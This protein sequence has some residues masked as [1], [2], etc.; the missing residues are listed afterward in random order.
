M[1]TFKGFPNSDFL[2]PNTIAKRTTQFIDKN[3]GTVS[4]GSS[5]GT[6]FPGEPISKN[7]NA[8]TVLG[9]TNNGIDN[10]LS[11]GFGLD[12]FP[13]GTLPTDPPFEANNNPLTWKN[14]NALNVLLGITQAQGNI[15]NGTGLPFPPFN[16]F[17]SQ[18]AVQFPFNPFPAS[19]GAT[20]SASPPQAW[21]MMAMGG[22]AF[23]AGNPM[24]APPGTDAMPPM[25]GFMLIP[26]PGLNFGNTGNAPTAFGNGGMPSSLPMPQPWPMQQNLQQNFII[27]QQQSTGFNGYSPAFTSF[28][29]PRHPMFEPLSFLMGSLMSSMMVMLAAVSPEAADAPSGQAG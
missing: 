14:P 9:Q 20:P 23:Q 19:A 10:I 2:S 27:N 29:T 17:P 12:F 28:H 13:P 24:I 6:A 22:A 25:Q 8:K 21:A 4:S 15:L 7:A 3:L 1:S 16:P 26:T 18:Q 5:G 11:P